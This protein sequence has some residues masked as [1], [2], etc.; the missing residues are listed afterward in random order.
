MREKRIAIFVDGSN[1]SAALRVAGYMMDYDKL[2]A[3]YQ[4]HGTVVSATYF[5]ALPPKGVFAPIRAL[6][7]R[8]GYHGWQ[9]KSKETKE[10]LTDEGIFKLKGNMDIELVVKAMKLVDQGNV[11]FPLTDFI[12]CSGDGDFCALVEA[13]QDKGVHVT[14]ISSFVQGDKNMVADELRRQVDTFV[15]LRDSRIREQF[16]LTLKPRTEAEQI[17]IADRRRRFMEGQ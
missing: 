17:V 2:L 10:L 15:D 11:V 16:Q 8:L 14:A 7:D 5:T 3:H 13:L 12:L 4:E 6:V 1:F 9:I